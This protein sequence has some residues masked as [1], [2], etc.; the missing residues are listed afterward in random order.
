MPV[1]N[2]SLLD[3]PTSQAFF[4]HML[5]GVAYCRVIF[6]RGRA[7]DFV[8]Y[9]TNPAFSTLTG[10]DDVCGRRVAEFFPQLRESDPEVFDFYGRVAVT[11]VAERAE[12]KV[13]ALGEWF[14]ISAYCPRPGYFVTVFDVITRRKRA[15]L[16]TAESEARFRH[17]AALT[18]DVFYAC[19]RGADGLFRVEWL[20]GSVE[21]VFGLTPEAFMALG[22][23]R[24]LL[25]DED[26]PL[27]DRHI[28]GLAPGQSSDLILR[29]RHRDGSLR[30]LRSCAVIDHAAA[31]DGAHLLYGAL[32]D[33]SESV[34]AEAALRETLAEAERFRVALDHAPSYIYIKDGQG[35]YVYGNRA[36][37]ELFGCVAGTLAGQDDRSFFAPETA[38][39]IREIDRRVLAGET[40][41]EEIEVRGGG[42][43]DGQVFWQEKAP[44]YADPARREVWG[45]CGVST[46]I[47]ARK[48]LERA[49]ELQANTDSLTGLDSRAHFLDVAGKELA[50]LRRHP[51]PMALAMLDLD[52][53]KRVNDRHG[54][55][56]GDRVLVAFARVC[57]HKLREI[58]LMG[59]LGGEEFAVLLPDT[60]G[61]QAREVIERLLRAV[62]EVEVRVE[63]GPPIHMTA[64][65]GL[66]ICGDRD[67]DMDALLNR[68]D[69]ALYEA[70]RLGRNRL[71]V[72]TGP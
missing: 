6:D 25:V 71:V 50:R 63:G 38:A 13:N 31:G 36:T 5:N 35:R 64:S 69:A 62:A 33:V 56:V 41:R 40:T 21:R 45:L 61:V 18:S 3:L 54:H 51:A 42:L 14:A 29:A 7:A 53:F 67:T 17:F 10:L 9:Y 28:T 58:D 49:L 26:G 47:T 11:G 39:R 15:E 22:C 23:W 60:A 37:L 72:A 16:A 12:L 48:R 30:H 1:S 43:A 27:F 2:G 24:T 34:R 70:K 46:D 65:A 55:E 20:G 19:R 4:E 8:F 57:R 59:R 66:A 52:H 68:A 32:Q 44:I